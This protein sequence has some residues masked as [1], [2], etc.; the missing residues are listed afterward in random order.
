MSQLKLATRDNQTVFRPGE[1]IQGAAGWQLDPPPKSVEVRLFWY[2][3]G[4]GTEDAAIAQTVRF[5]HPKPEEARPFQ[6]TVP[7]A[8]YSFSGKLISLI[9]ALEL[10][11]EPGRE[12]TR[13]ELVVSPS[14]KEIQLG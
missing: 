1:E 8:P 4:K 12:S 13:L 5:D 14:G 7:E 9:W 10:V 2:T 11:A 3:R 6:F